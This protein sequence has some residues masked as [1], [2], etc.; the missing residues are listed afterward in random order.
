MTGV[1]RFDHFSDVFDID[2]LVLDKYG[3]LNIYL[4]VDMRLFID[5]FLLYCSKKK[6]Y[7]ALHNE[8][9]EYLQFLHKKARLGKL[10]TKDLRKYYS[11]REIKQNWLGYTLGG[12]NGRGLGIGFAKELDGKLS[13]PRAH[14]GHPS[15]SKGIHFEK[16]CLSCRGVDADK[17]SD[18][19]VH[20]IHNFLLEYTQSFAEKYIS[21]RL[22]K[23]IKI[24]KSFFNYST[25]QW[26]EKAFYLPC[27]KSDY[28]ILTPKDLL[29]RDPLWIN[30]DHFYNNFRKTIE[31]VITDTSLK[32]DTNKYFTD[33][34]FDE[35]TDREKNKIIRSAFKAYPET[36]DYYIKG[37]ESSAARAVYTSREDV[38]YTE[39]IFI[40]YARALIKE[41]NART[42]FYK[43]LGF[44]YPETKNRLLI[45]KEFIEKQGGKKY[46][47]YNGKPLKN[48]DDIARL[49]S[50]ILCHPD[51]SL[52]ESIGRQSSI[53]KSRKVEVVF[54]SASNSNLRRYLSNRVTQFKNAGSRISTIFV[55]FCFSAEK[56]AHTEKILS[57]LEIRKRD[58]LILI[59]A[60]RKK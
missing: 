50:F 43:H 15:I 9:I 5:P 41:L 17:T 52:Y 54:K 27:F 7:Q 22:C 26:E 60:A 23:N 8:I 35:A 31:D 29:R 1:I 21:P 14:P 47:Y 46:F 37:R 32:R 2:P 18:F 16:Y 38:K 25:E 3:A 42:D 55:I 58:N 59:Q 30:R 36:L 56:Y 51:D 24:R 11:F 34:Q 12:N 33:N 4:C 6:Q 19:T 57:A 28:V 39:T 10:S 53:N 13:K 20:L 44:A 45:L 48:E 40:K 49:Y